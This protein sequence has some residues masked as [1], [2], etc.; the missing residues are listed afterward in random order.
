MIDDV[1]SQVFPIYRFQIALVIDGSHMCWG[2]SWS[3]Y[4]WVSCSN[5]NGS[6]R[7]FLAAGNSSLGTLHTS[8]LS[9]YYSLGYEDANRK[10]ISLDYSLLNNNIYYIIIRGPADSGVTWP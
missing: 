1:F 5:H 8:L 6:S 7:C 2:N 3:C 9:G 10:A 4:N